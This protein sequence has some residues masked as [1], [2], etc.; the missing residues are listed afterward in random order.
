MLGWRGIFGALGIAAIILA[1]ERRN[2]WA[3]FRQM[4]WPSWLFAIVSAAF[5]T[6]FNPTRSHCTA[7]PA[8]KIAPSS[9]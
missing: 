5:F 8:M 9:A 1:L 7:A 4:G 3:G 6:S 2:T